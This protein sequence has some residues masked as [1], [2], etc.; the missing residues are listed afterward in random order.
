MNEDD[1]ELRELQALAEKQDR[2]DGLDSKPK[3]QTRQ[4]EVSV[5]FLESLGGEVIEDKI[6]YGQAKIVEIR[7]GSEKETQLS[8]RP[9][10]ELIF[11]RSKDRKVRHDRLNRLFSRWTVSLRGKTSRYDTQRELNKANRGLWKMGEGRDGEEGEPSIA[12]QAAK[13]LLACHVEIEL[14]LRRTLLVL[15]LYRLHEKAK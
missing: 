14:K 4:R 12:F 7:F 6:G 11:Q 10:A 13:Q 1:P 15:L 5:A 8:F 2:Q 9:E 3:A